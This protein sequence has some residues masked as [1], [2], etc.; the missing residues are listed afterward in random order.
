MINEESAETSN[1]QEANI[2]GNETA[3]RDAS[4]DDREGADENTPKR[5]NMLLNLA[6]NIVIPVIILSKF[7]GEQH[8]GPS[9]GIVVAL[10]FP[11]GYGVNDYFRAGKVNFF[12]ALGVFSV[13][14][15][16]GISL[17]ELD[18]KYI[19]YKEAGIPLLLG[20]AV[21]GSL[22]T[23]W[24]LVRTFIYSNLVLDT[25]RIDTALQQ[26]GTTELFEKAMV[27]VSWIFASS[28]FLSAILNYVLARIILVAPPGTEEFNAQL[29]KMTW[30]SYPVIAVP[31]MIISISAFLYLCKRI[32]KL[33]QLE[34][35]DIVIQPEK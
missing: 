21:I 26:H 24:P 5:E 1:R 8:L 31:A 7:S 20:L 16:G 22:K 6:F 2:N 9:W 28:F 12:S 35:E 29:G 15:T 23:P 19:A 10:A 17:L 25:K 11:I 32:T 13:V 30:M 4:Q 3:S 34:L 33:T 27:R 18:P 14:M